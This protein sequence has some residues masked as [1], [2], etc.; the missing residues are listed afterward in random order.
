[1]NRQSFVERNR[2]FG[3]ADFEWSRDDVD[4][5]NAAGGG[6]SLPISSLALTISRQRLSIDASSLWGSAK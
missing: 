2:A 1:L 4:A 6:A 5:V 3:R